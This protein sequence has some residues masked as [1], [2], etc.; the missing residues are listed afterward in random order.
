MKNSI[1]FIIALISIAAV[2]CTDSVE[3]REAVAVG[4]APVL[5]APSNGSAR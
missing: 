4:T 2:S 1:K 5:V 3:D